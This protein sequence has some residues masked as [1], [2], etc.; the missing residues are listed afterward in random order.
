MEGYITRAWH[1]PYH[2]H[3]IDYVYVF[4]STNGF[5]Q[6]KIIYYESGGITPHLITATQRDDHMEIEVNC[7]V[8]GCGVLYDNNSGEFTFKNVR[9]YKL[10]FKDWNALLFFTDTGYK[11]F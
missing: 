1:C 6:E 4:G 2:K 11:I 10:S 7:C 8:I 5:K 3:E 9:K